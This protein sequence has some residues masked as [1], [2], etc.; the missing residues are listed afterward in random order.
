V[1]KYY[2]YVGDTPG[3]NNVINTGEITQTSYPMTGLPVGTTLYA[4]LW[5]RVGGCWTAAPV[6]TFRP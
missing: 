5:T 4:K 6:L 2:L 3:A 1:Q